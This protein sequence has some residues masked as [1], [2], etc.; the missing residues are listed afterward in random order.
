MVSL[1][2]K[3]LITFHGRVASCHA[4]EGP[5]DKNFDV[6]I[7]FADMPERDT[8]KLREFIAMLPGMG[9]DS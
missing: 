7:E 6:G 2:D 1:P 8:A 4:L 5:T 9:K 3:T